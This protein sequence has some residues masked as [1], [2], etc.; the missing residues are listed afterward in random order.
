[1]QFNAIMTKTDRYKARPYFFL[2]FRIIFATF[3]K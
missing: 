2:S 1:M 3:E